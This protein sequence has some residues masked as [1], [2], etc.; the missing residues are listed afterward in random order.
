MSETESPNL[1][2]TGIAAVRLIYIKHQSF[3]EG[4]VSER[5]TIPALVLTATLAMA[6]FNSAL[7]VLAPRKS[8]PDL[9]SVCF[10]LS[11]DMEEA[12]GQC[13]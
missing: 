2:F 3:V 4:N 10:G 8:V 11:M 12:I 1:K 6:V 5:F 9:R 7:I 13:L